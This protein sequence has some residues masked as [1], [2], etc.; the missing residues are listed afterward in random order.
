[1]TWVK[2]LCR[3]DAI[4][5]TF[6][7]YQ[8]V[9]TYLVKKEQNDPGLPLYW[10]AIRSLMVPPGIPYFNNRSRRVYE[11]L[12]LLHGK[13]WIGYNTK[14]PICIA[15]VEISLDGGRTS[16]G[17][18]TLQKYSNEPYA[19]V[20]WVFPWQAMEGKY[21]LCSLAYDS[22][23]QR[24]PLLSDTF[25]NFLGMGNNSVQLIEVFVTKSNPDNQNSWSPSSVIPL[26]AK[27]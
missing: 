25:W 26:V 13:V 6:E 24:Q 1:M 11:G 3:I 16:I 5:T 8:Q 10:M 27:L 9:G 4:T 22:K 18:A 12:V 17:E 14:D 15:K 7:G 23:G 21:Q 20:N 2:W 19:W